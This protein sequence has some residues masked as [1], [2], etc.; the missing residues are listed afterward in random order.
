[1]VLEQKYTEQSRTIEQLI[2]MVHELNLELRNTV[3]LLLAIMLVAGAE[4]FM[5]IANH[6]SKGLISL[7]NTIMEVEASDDL[8][9]IATIGTSD[10]VDSLAAAFN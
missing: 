5:F 9:R 6:I 10:E 7:R 3:Y 2:Q 8:S 1:M 4:T